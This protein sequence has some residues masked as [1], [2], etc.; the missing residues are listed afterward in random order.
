MRKI[1]RMLIV[2]AV[3]S[4]ALSGCNSGA[5]T[6]DGE[7]TSSTAEPVQQEEIQ[8]EWWPEDSLAAKVPTPRSSSGEIKNN[9]ETILQAWVF[10]S[11]EAAFNEYVKRC[12]AAG[13]T[14]DEEKIGVNFEAFNEEGYKVSVY[15]WKNDHKFALNLEP[16]IQ[17][18]EIV[19]PTTGPAAGVPAP[20][21]TMGKNDVNTST[22][23]CVQI[24][25][26]PLKGYSA[27]VDSLISAG[28]DVD[29]NRQDKWFSATNADGYQVIA[30]YQGFDTMS[31]R[32]A[33]P[34]A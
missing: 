27:Y 28:F 15:F 1:Q 31:V 6:N 10:D 20:S 4:L 25:K 33:S 16:P 17:L 2:A 3:M 7:G 23:Y 11:D 13:F 5:A 8:S 9:N 19:W 24:G 29:Y 21:S 12:E 26:T 18:S 14:V 32:V 30:E 22:R 34:D